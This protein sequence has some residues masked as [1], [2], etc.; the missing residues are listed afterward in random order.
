MIGVLVGDDDGVEFVRVFT[1]FG[2]AL[3]GLFAA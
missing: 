1:G 2:Q 3:E